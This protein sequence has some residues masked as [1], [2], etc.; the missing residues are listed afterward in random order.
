MAY[1]IAR[2]CSAPA[3]RPGHIASEPGPNHPCPT[4]LFARRAIE[5]AFWDACQTRNGMPTETAH[6]ALAWIEARTDWTHYGMQ[7]PED[8]SVRRELW[9]QFDWCCRWLGEDPNQVRSVGLPRPAR[10]QCAQERHSLRRHVAGL[11]AVHEARKRARLAQQ[12][13]LE[14]QISTAATLPQSQPQPFIARHLTLSLGHDVAARYRRYQ[15]YC[16]LVSVMPMREGLW[17]LHCD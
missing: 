15:E 8:E 16:G 17:R 4:L 7:P 9:G 11:S 5:Q 13:K 3:I 10:P 14:Q 2:E 6:E 12:R 1:Y